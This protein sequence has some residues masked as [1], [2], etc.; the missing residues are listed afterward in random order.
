MKTMRARTS[1]EAWFSYWL[2]CLCWWSRPVSRQAFISS[3][4]PPSATHLLLSSR[5]KKLAASRLSLQRSLDV[6]ALALQEPNWQLL[7]LSPHGLEDFFLI[8]EPAHIPG[9]RG[10]AAPPWVRSPLQLGNSGWRRVGPTFHAFAWVYRHSLTHALL[11]SMRARSPPLNPLDVWVW[12]VRL[13]MNGL[14]P[15]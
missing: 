10:P 2:C 12:E 5:G 15:I 3:S 1:T 13:V 6:A 4:P 7:L 9:C 11:E 8:C 14:D